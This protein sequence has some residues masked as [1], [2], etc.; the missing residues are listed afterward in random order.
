MIVLFILFAVCCIELYFFTKNSF[1]RITDDQNGTRT[2]Q[3][4]IANQSEEQ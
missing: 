4:R 3:V 2:I 1:V